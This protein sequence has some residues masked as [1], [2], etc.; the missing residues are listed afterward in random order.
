VVWYCCNDGRWPTLTK[1]R[2]GMRERAPYMAASLSRASAEV[3]CFGGGDTTEGWGDR[4]S[5][6]RGGRP[7]HKQCE[8]AVLVPPSV[9]RHGGWCPCPFHGAHLVQNGERRLRHKDAREREPLLLPQREHVG[10]VSNGV[11]R[12]RDGALLR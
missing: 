7:C 5:R 1:V 9:A 3:A 2:P 10:P 11:Q 6:A 4:G 8:S 12:P